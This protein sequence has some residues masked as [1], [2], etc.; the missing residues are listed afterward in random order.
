M[1]INFLTSNKKELLSILFL[2]TTSLIII[3][4]SFLL[5]II[6]SL[7]LSYLLYNIIKFINSYGFTKNTSFLIVYSLFLTLF[8][9]ILFILLPL[10]FKQLVGLFNDLPFMIQKIKFVT[11]KFIEKYPILISQEQTNLL[12]SNI[13][14]YVQ[15]MGKTIISA[16]ILSI[17]ITIKW[18]VCI[19]FIPILI[20]FLLKDKEDII[21]WFKFLIP[22]TFFHI[23]KI[24]FTINKQINNY[25]RGKII[26]III[27]II[28][29]YLLFKIYKLAYNDLLSFAVGLSVVLP[30]IGAIIVSI[31]VLFI[32]AVQFGTSIDFINIILIYTLIQFLD[33]NLLVPILFSEAVNLHPLSIIIA[34]IIFGS[35][36]NI[37]G[38]FFAIPLAILVQALIKLY[39]TTNYKLY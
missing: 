38:V 39:L 29:N 17:T 14:K 8:F 27:M 21:Y 23:E 31:P 28:F 12:F 3:Y 22:K 6:I 16:S 35:T 34:I 11:S 18:I 30:Y 7:T 20:F 36:L 37:Y 9:L 1:T 13:I 10:I 15:S 33:G 25:V 26:E 24:W 5:P 19:L 32:S 4:S 2:A